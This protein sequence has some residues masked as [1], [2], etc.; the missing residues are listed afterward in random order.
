MAHCIYT[1]DGKGNAISS[2]STLY[3]IIHGVANVSLA[4]RRGRERTRSVRYCARK[5]PR[6][7]AER[8]REATKLVDLSDVRSIRNE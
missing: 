6:E 8:G 7:G 2:A 3:V 4:G 5:K 1:S